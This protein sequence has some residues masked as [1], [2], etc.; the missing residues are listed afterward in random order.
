MLALTD[1]ITT[2]AVSLWPPGEL[3]LSRP[4]AL[5]PSADVPTPDA[6]PGPGHQGQRRRGVL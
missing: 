1:V 2:A 3:P 5:H 4:P 6:D